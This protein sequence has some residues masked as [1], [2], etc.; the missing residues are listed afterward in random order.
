[1]HGCYVALTLEFP[2]KGG[3]CLSYNSCVFSGVCIVAGHRDYVWAFQGNILFG[4][5]IKI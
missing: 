2:G 1:M 3:F 5:N 4:R